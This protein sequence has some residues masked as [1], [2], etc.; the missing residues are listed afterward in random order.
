MITVIK[1]DN[2]K[3]WLNG[4]GDGQALYRITTRLQ[5]VEDGNLGDVKPVGS[6]VSEMRINYG[7]GY[8]LYFIQRGNTVVV[9]LAGGDK[10]S[11]DRDIKKAKELAQEWR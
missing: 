2:F 1:T 3:K 4:I 5:R 11:Q 9:M 7:S 8:R 10:S 6:G